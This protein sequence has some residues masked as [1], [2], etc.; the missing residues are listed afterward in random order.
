MGKTVAHRV[1]Y[2]KLY[3]TP[4]QTNYKINYKTPVEKAKKPMNSKRYSTG[5]S[6]IQQYA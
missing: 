1:G 6:S 3:F 2:D 4:A 5:L